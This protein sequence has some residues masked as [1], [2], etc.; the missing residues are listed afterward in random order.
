MET[1]LLSQLLFFISCFAH[2]GRCFKFVKL[3][4]SNSA[5]FAV[6]P[7]RALTLSDVPSLTS[8]ACFQA[9]CGDS[10][11]TP[12]DKLIPN[13]DIITAPPLVSNYIIANPKVFLEKPEIAVLY[14]FDVKS[15]AS[16][17]PL[18]KLALELPIIY[19]ADIHPEYGTLG[20]M[21]NKLSPSSMMNLHPTLKSLRSRPIYKGGLQNKGST[22][23]ML[24]TKIGFPENRSASAPIDVNR[25]V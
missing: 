5:L 24:H 21:L 16:S 8:K 10:V 18:E 4:P 11:L 25:I 19:I 14:G 6:D 13:V 1:K 7:R 22:F 9:V 15:F 3:V 23:T 17:T 2:F 20:F 12:K